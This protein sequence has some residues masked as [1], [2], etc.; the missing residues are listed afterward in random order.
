M[1]NYFLPLLASCMVLSI[2]FVQCN[3]SPVPE[4][5]VTTEDNSAIAVDTLDVIDTLDTKELAEVKDRPVVKARPEVKDRP[6]V[7]APPRVK[8]RSEVKEQPKIAE[9]PEV[10]TQPEVKAQPEE[11]P[12]VKKPALKSA[13]FIF[14]SIKA[15]IDGSSSLHDWESKVTKMEGKGTFMLKDNTLSTIKDMEIIIA[16]KG[17]ISKEGSKMDNKTYETFRSDQNPNI[18]YTCSN[19][20]VKIN[21]DHGVVIETTG[22][23]SMAGTSKSV[24]LTAKG[25]ELANGDLQLSVSHKIKMTDYKMEPPVMLLG[26]IKVGDEITV[27]FDFVLTQTK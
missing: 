14:K 4:A 10:K 18:I 20:A 11:I 22:Q 25:K 8:E 16:V 19:A 12:I 13:D 6:V 15:S 2:A 27:H 5:Q 21:A 9:H 17:I 23:L 26:T 7:K 1:K 3:S 24:S